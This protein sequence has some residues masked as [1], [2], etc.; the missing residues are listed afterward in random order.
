M[1]LFLW[2]EENIALLG[3]SISM[4]NL[5]QSKARDVEFQNFV[6]ITSKTS[7]FFATTSDFLIF[8]I[9]EISSKAFVES[10]YGR[11]LWSI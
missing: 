8:Y 5:H 6:L 9:I 3:F 2:R 4:S 1:C 10:W 7:F 11:V